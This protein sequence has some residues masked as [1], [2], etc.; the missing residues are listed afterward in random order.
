M[1]DSFG[2]MFKL[3][4]TN[5]AVCK[6]KMRGMLVCKDRWLRVQFG[7]KRLHKIDAMTWEVLYMKATAYLR[8]FIDMPLY[9][10]FNKENKP[11]ELWEKI[12]IMLENKN[13]IHR[14]SV[15]RKIMR[16]RYQDGS[17]MA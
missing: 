12:D 6:S 7:D 1:E 17:S 11:D 4:G 2:G 10:N 14:V 16:L 3:T 15:F 13:V 9:N 5:Y 8:C